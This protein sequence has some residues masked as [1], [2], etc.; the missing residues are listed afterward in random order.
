[1]YASKMTAGF[2]TVLLLLLA[3]TD[4]RPVDWAQ[5]VRLPSVPPSHGAYCNFEQRYSIMLPDRCTC[6]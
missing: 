5:Q 6:L 4:G 3:S 2:L 1:M